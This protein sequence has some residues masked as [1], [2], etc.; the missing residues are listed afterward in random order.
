VVVAVMQVRIVWVTVS[1][2]GMSVRVGVRFAGLN[3]GLVLVLMVFVVR[4]KMAPGQERLD[5]ETMSFAR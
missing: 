1:Q 3:V 2:D 5:A 4:V